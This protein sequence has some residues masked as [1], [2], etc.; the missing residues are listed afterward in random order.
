MKTS[1]QKSKK[2]KSIQILKQPETLTKNELRALKGGSALDEHCVCD[3][4]SCY[5]DS[6]NQCGCNIWVL[7]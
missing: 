5:Q 3:G 4:G 2:S 1:K 6:C 7:F